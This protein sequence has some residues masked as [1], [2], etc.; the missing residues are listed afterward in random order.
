MP[1]VDIYN[2]DNAM[3]GVTDNHIRTQIIALY[4]TNHPIVPNAVMWNSP[5]VIS[6]ISLSRTPVS[7]LVCDINYS[8]VLL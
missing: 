3:N 8:P 1:L 7:L 6:V 4:D 5:V 2:V